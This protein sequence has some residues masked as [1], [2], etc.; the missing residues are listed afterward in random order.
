MLTVAI[1]GG[2]AYAGWRVYSERT[3]DAMP[4]ALQDYVDG[5]GVAFEPPFETVSPAAVGGHAWSRR[6]GTG[7]T[8]ER[9]RAD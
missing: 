2:V 4:A 5:D 9:A 8:L 7:A 3:A 1:L 6:V